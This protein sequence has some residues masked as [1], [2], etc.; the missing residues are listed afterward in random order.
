M[1]DMMTTR[2]AVLYGTDEDLV[3][4]TLT[5]APPRRGEVQIRMGAAGI[6]HSDAHVI[7]G[8]AAQVLPCVLGH[9]GAGTVTAIG[10]GVTR[11]SVG[12]HVV[13]SWLP[14][15]GACRQCLRGRTHLCL[16]CQ[17]PVWDGTL[18]DG[19]CRLTGAD[20]EVRQL[21]TLGCWSEN[22]VVPQESCVS[23]DRSVP[24]E[25]AA[26][27][28]CAVTTGVGAVLNRARV[29][30]GET[31]AIVGM[32][33]VGLSVLMGAK[34]QGASQIICIDRQAGARDLAMALGATSFIL[35]DGVA[36][37]AAQVMALTGIG[38][39]HVFEAVGKRALQR[40]AVDYC[41]PGGQVIYVGLDGPDATIPLPTTEITRSE[42]IITGSIYGSA[43]TDRDF[44]LYAEKYR[45]GLLPVDTMIGTRHGL[46]DINAAIADMMR[47][48][49]GRGVITF[50]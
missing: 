17:G 13:L 7:S 38:A 28:G 5:L 12:D 35:A 42:K 15:C 50:P 27:I 10:D 6:C 21:G 45:D 9:E 39:D 19:T 49:C 4:E 48:G 3:I 33:G 46:D 36:D 40:Q 23:I 37:I 22:V 2:A 41:C 16:E 20:G 26:L 47:G 34:L 1:K 32:G 14:F 43:C 30:Q 18:M 24:M 11:V 31:V 25:V 29:N 44:V 8:Q